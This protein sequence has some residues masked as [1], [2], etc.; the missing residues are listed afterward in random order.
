MSSDL[1]KLM[2]KM[3]KNK[4]VPKEEE[5]VEEED[6]DLNEE[7]VD[8][9]EDDDTDYAE[10]DEEE[11]EKEEVKEVPKVKEE[12]Y[13]EV[14]KVEEK[15]AEEDQ[16]H[17]IDAEVGLLQ[18]DGIFRRELL[19]TLKELVEVQKAQAEILM[20]LNKGSNK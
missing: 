18:N 12:K 4:E 11:E 9:G 7:V 16:T 6:L 8:D 15:V 10:D 14:P 17:P 19:L 5:K 2:E 13:I 3:K 20:K 1:D